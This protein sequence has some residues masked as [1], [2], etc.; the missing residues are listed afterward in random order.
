YDVVVSNGSGAATSQV[1]TLTV[2]LPPSI[3]QQPVSLVV[4]QGD[5][6]MFSVS[7]S[8]DAP[9]SYQWRLNAG[10]I[11]GATSSSYAVAS[12]QPAQAGN[13]DVVVSNGAGAVTSQVATLTVRVPPSITQQPVS[14][15][16]TQGSSASF[17]V[18]AG[19]DAPLSYQW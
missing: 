19:G 11:G 9:L 5:S 10:N 17:S 2:R 8:G 1:A 4:T 14:L 12:A 6:A 15:V 16:V 18:G 7:A 13:Y 3:T